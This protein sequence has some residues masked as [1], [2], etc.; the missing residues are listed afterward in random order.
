MSIIWMDTEFE[1]KQCYKVYFR[2]VYLRTQLL[3]AEHVRFM[4]SRGYTLQPA[5]KR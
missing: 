1:G 2:A 4:L 3:T 5:G